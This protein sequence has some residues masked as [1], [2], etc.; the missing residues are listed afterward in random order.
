MSGLS[1]SAAQTLDT[2]ILGAGPAGLAVG[3]CLQQAGSPFELLEQKDAVGSAWRGHYRRLH[4]HTV[5]GHSALP[6]LPFPKEY[7]TYPSRQQVV[8]YLEVYARKFGLAPK[9]GEVVTAVRR[10]RRGQG[11]EV[12]SNGRTLHARRVVVATGYN[13]VPE[14]PSWP[15]EIAGE[16]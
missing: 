4:L 15:G 3:A 10:A 7:P 14:R 1:E 2:L 11:Y 13:R 12:E 8:D 16:R 5:K 9:T 6:G